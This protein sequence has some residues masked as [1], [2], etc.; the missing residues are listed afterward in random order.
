MKRTCCVHPAPLQ[1]HPLQLLAEVGATNTLSEHSSVDSTTTEASVNG[2]Q[3]CFMQ[4][5]FFV[6]AGNTAHSCR[7]GQRI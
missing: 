7:H 6:D 2:L 5:V 1:S 4:L 3:H